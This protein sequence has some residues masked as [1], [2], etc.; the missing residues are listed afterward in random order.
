MFKHFGAD[1]WLGLLVCCAALLLIF[2]WIPLDVETGIIEKVRRQFIIGDSL[3]PTVA[4]AVIGIGGLLCLLRPNA[5]DP[6]PGRDNL[7]WLATLLVI[8][9]VSL[10]VMR[11]VGPA[12]VDL[13][14]EP[15][16]RALRSTPPWNYVGYLSGGALL[17]AGL[18]RAV[19]G[20]LRTSAVLVAIGA[21]LAIALLYDLPFDNLQLP[22]N[23]DL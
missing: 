5:D 14:A 22:P 6:A 8:L 10:T 16:Y 12:L 4:G 20:R 17:I 9:A 15:S 19:N 7:I 18:N 13:V 11:F 1:R 2:V 21:T 3:G 23:G